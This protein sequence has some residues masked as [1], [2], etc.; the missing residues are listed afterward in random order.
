[1]LI[2]FDSLPYAGKWEEPK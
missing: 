1:M 2:F